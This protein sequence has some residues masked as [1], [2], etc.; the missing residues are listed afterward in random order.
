VE[1]VTWPT[2]KL[3]RK[4]CQSCSRLWLKPAVSRSRGTTRIPSSRA[5]WSG[6]KL[7]HRLTSNKQFH[8]EPL[9]RIMMLG[10]RSVILFALRETSRVWQC[11]S[12]LC[13]NAYGL[14]RVQS[15]R[16]LMVMSFNQADI[17]TGNALHYTNASIDLN[18]YHSLNNWLLAVCSML[19]VRTNC[20]VLQCFFILNFHPSCRS[21]Y[22]G[23]CQMPAFM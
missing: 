21:R 19:S 17:G 16:P 8:D 14:S 2:A 5:P 18:R 13:Y 22:M 6:V 4:W 12:D 7:V 20:C 23:K 15:I 11:F 3:N 9:Y 10:L 1:S